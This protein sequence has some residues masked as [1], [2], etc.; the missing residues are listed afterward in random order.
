MSIYSWLSAPRSENGVRFADERAGWDRLSYA[1]LADDAR[2]VAADLAARGVG[3]GDVVAIALPASRDGLAALFGA[4]A[5]GCCVCMLPVPGYGTGA[6][7]PAHVAAI[8]A[9]AR[10]AVTFADADA[11]RLLA[12][13]TPVDAV[14]YGTGDAPA[15]APARVAVLQFTSGSTRNARG[16]QLTGDNIEAN[17]APLYRW[18][19]WQEGDGCSV[20]LP[21]NHDMGL[22]ACVMTIAR[23]GDMWLMRPDQFIRDPARWLSSFGPGRAAHA[24]G[25]A[26]GFGYAARR[27]RPEQW[28]ALDLSG[29][30]SALVGGE[31]I[32]PGALRAFAAAAASS[33]FSPAVFRPAYGLAENT[34][35]VTAGA[36]GRPGRVVRP[37]WEKLR[38]GEP[39]SVLDTGS[40]IPVP[41]DETAGDA[42]GAGWLTGHGLPVPG[43]EVGVEVV[44]VDGTALPGGTLGEIAVTG[45]SL[46]VGY[47]DGEPFGA[48]LRTGD[49]GFVHDGDLYVLGRMGDSLK[50]RART[51]YV[52]DLEFRVRT[53]IGHSR[54]AVVSMSDGGRPGVAVFAESEPGAWTDQVTQVLRAELGPDPEIAIIAGPRGLICRTSSGKP[55]RREMWRLWSAGQLTGT[56]LQ[57]SQYSERTWLTARR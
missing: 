37:D 14:R 22:M 15:A 4:W 45:Q 29:W 32:D 39:V 16:I 52:E 6:D 20:W 54:L 46:A 51:V 47:F 7:Y 43:D 10:P 21:L 34:S 27:L 44:D 8:L 9:Q 35:A 23:Q 42:D 31:V 53:V 36:A 11:A 55:R 18:T 30:R 49:A 5:A 19:G 57:L 2:A 41:D 33:G 3:H 25:P 13:V 26:F 28:A 56:R 1:A 40:L 12:D 50:I 48:R 17:L 38:F 24:G